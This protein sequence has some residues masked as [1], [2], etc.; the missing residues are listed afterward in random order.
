[1]PLFRS[2]LPSTGGTLTGNLVVA[3]GGTSIN[4]VDRGA[5]TN[6]AA[7][8]LRTAAVDRWSLQMINDSTNNLYLSDSANGKTVLA[9]V[10]GATAP[11]IQLLSATA[12]HGSGVGVIGLTD[13]TTVPTT[14]PSGGGILYSQAGALKWRGSS[15]TVTTLGAA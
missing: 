14:N 13:A 12:S 3:T 7:Y 11:N 8:A 15:G 10:P 2:S 6:F 9:V 1:M 4:A 5:V